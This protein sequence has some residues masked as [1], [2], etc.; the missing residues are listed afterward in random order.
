MFTKESLYLAL[1]LIDAM[2]SP[3]S[4]QTS[5]CTPPIRPFLPSDPRDVQAYADLLRRDFE[6]YIRDFGTYLR[7]L[8]TERARVFQEAQEVTA[9]YGRFQELTTGSR[10]TPAE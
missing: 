4:A 10:L 8:D 7:C 3:L 2:V 9:D 1:Y 6:T 5:G